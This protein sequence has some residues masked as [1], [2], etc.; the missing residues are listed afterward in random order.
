MT[1]RNFRPNFLHQ[2]NKF[3][4]NKFVLAKNDIENYSTIEFKSTTT[5]KRSNYYLSIYLIIFQY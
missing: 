4:M 5:S 2:D 1:S 3:D